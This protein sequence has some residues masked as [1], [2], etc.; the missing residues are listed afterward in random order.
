[1]IELTN[2]VSKN[3]VTKLPLCTI[4]AHLWRTKSRRAQAPFRRLRRSSQILQP[5]FVAA[6]SVATLTITATTSMER[7]V[8]NE[9]AEGNVSPAI[10]NLLFLFQTEPTVLATPTE[11][12]RW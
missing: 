9:G 12:P 2:R 8:Y 11:K 6:V 1:M 10:I 4:A 3:K 5:T 7:S